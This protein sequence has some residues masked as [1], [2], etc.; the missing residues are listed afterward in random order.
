MYII[1]CNFAVMN[2]DKRYDILLIGD[3]SNLHSQLGRS[4][5]AMGH[6]VTVMSE[7]CGFQQTER[8][9]DISRRPGRLG[10]AQLAWR[11]LSPL[12]DAMRGHDIVALQHPHFMQ[13]RPQ[14]L[15][16]FFDRLR[17]EN[18]RVFLTAAG[19][20]VT[21]LNEALR[22][23]S[24]LRYTE[25]RLG[26]E[27]SPLQ[28]AQSAKLAEWFTPQMRAYNDHV[29]GNVDGVVTALYEYDVAVR[30]VLG[31]D[32]VCYGG[33][34]IDC[35]AIKPVDIER[36]IDAVRFFLGRHSQRKIEK[37][38]DLLERAVNTV[39]RSHPGRAS[40]EIIEDRPYAEYLDMMHGSHVVLDQIYSYSPATNALIAMARGLNVVSGGETSFYDFIGERENR[41][42]INASPNFEQLVEIIDDVVMHPEFIAERGRCSREFVMRH[43]EAQAVAKRY[44]DFWTRGL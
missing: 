38:T 42:V 39:I 34:P 6:R 16:Y 10:G 41:P 36:D 13:L 4:L 15:R 2:V 12:H 5:R 27:P 33:I 37:G 22:S 14:R 35:Q 20:D 26:T 18:G 40:L 1:R 3:Y 19:T 11:C 29:Y 21:Y 32:K 24:P 17:G 43:N 7:G 8:D 25:W 23:D 31:D 44:L 30:R 28:K 9:I